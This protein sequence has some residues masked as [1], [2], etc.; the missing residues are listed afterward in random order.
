MFYSKRTSHQLASRASPPIQCCSEKSILAKQINDAI[1]LQQ[2][3]KNKR[4]KNNSI[5]FENVIIRKKTKISGFLFINVKSSMNFKSGLSLV[6]NVYIYFTLEWNCRKGNPH[7]DLF[8]SNQVRIRY[9]S[10][11]IINLY[12]SGQFPVCMSYNVSSVNLQ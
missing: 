3:L 8:L 5:F 10:T 1:Y 7:H 6:N 2:F 9:L 12:N 4:N 11:C